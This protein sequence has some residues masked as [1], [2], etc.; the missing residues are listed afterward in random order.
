MMPLHAPRASK[1]TYPFLFDGVLSCGGLSC[2]VQAVPFGPLSIGGYGKDTHSAK[3]NVWIQSQFCARSKNK[4]F[5]RIRQPRSEYSRYHEAFL[6][7]ADL[8]K[9]FVDFLQENMD[10]KR[11][12]HLSYFESEFHGWVTHHHRQ[13]D[14]VQRWL[15]V[16]GQTDFRVAIAAHVEHLWTE[17]TDMNDKLRCHFIWQEIDPRALRAIPTQL[18]VS[19]PSDMTVVTPLIFETFKDVYF[20]SRLEARVATDPVVKA[21]WR[22]RKKALGFMTDDYSKPALNAPEP[23]LKAVPMAISPGDVVGIK[24]DMEDT[25]ATSWGRTK[26]DIWFGGFFFLLC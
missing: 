18:S 25:H 11:T 9:H 20:S 12:V 2:Y 24:R 7:I 13:S 26:S 14:Q 17:A 19:A 10:N 23:M 5:F 22:A 16:F 6:W 15:K 1:G 4:T 3:D 21:A 8:G